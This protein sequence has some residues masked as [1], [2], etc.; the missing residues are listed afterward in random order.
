MCDHDCSFNRILEFWVLGVGFG[1]ARYLCHESHVHRF[2]QVH[3]L[4]FI[5]LSRPTSKSY[6]PPCLHSLHFA[7]SRATHPGIY[8]ATDPR[9]SNSCFPRKLCVSPTVSIA[10]SAQSIPNR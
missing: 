4:C 9:I 10:L 7:L 1:Y 6:L 5:V 8:K 2:T 3:L